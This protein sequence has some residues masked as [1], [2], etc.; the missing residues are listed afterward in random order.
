MENKEVLT[1]LQL[2][3]EIFRSSK[4]FNQVVENIC[5]QYGINQVQ[6]YIIGLSLCSKKTVSTIAQDLNLTKS[7]VSQA[8]VGL[9]IKRLVVKRPSLENKKVFYIIPTENAES[10]KQRILSI[11]ADKYIMIEN[12]MGKENLDLFVE[13]LNKFNQTVEELV[14]NNKEGIC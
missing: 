5:K 6:L 11:T 3:I 1:H 2:F 12:N 7:A 9:I 13:L 4:A 8:I 14:K 10:I